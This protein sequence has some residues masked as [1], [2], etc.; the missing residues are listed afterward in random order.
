MPIQLIDDSPAE[1]AAPPRANRHP[2]RDY[3]P[4]LLYALTGFTGLLAEQGFE[5]YIAL[6]VGATA[7]ASAVV[8]FTY[9]LGFALG[10]AAAGRL[11][12][13]RQIARPLLVYGLIELLVG[14]SCVAFSYAFHG[15]VETL[16]PLQNLL[17]GTALRFQARFLC[18]CILVLPTAALM[19]ASFPL[20]ASALDGEFACS[21]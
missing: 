19:G 1:A 13:G 8:L 2:W 6:L 4:F 12:K 16:A 15:V 17:G 21:V 14:A 5:K 18:G 3:A 20:I 11:I 10:G 9:F 7:S